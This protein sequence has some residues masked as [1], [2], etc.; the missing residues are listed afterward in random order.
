MRPEFDIAN[1]FFQ[2][3]L[4]KKGFSGNIHWLFRENILVKKGEKE[5]YKFILN[6][7]LNEPNE[8]V[9]TIYD[10]LKD[11]NR[12]IFFYTF[13]KGQDFTYATIAGEDYDFE[14]DEGDLIKEEWN[15]KFGFSSYFD[16]DEN[17]IEFVEEG[18][19]KMN[20]KET[21]DIGPFDYFYLAE[22]FK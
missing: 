13:I 16:L 6:P 22:Y 14:I 11:S 3:S 10:K 20:N 7:D 9:K 8:K 15:L 19:N 18:W 1:D 4:I 21:K 12:E 5:R 17:E 2:R